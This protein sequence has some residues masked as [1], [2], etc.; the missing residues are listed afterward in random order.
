MTPFSGPH[1][2]I[3][4]SPVDEI[5]VETKPPFN[6]LYSVW[7]PSHF[8]TLLE[9]HF[10]EVAYRTFRLKSGLPVAIRMTPLHGGCCGIRAQVFAPRPFTGAERAY[11]S[12]RLRLAYGLDFPIKAFYE[13]V[14][15]D[16]ALVGGPIASLYGMR[17]SC[18][19]TL[20][21]IL[22]ISLVLQ[23]TTAKRSGQ[24]LAVLLET[25]GDSMLIDGQELY[26][27][28]DVNR[29]A[30]SSE[31]ELREGCRLG[32]R[33]RYLQAIAEG[34]ARGVV[35]EDRVRRLPEAEAKVEL[36]RL[37]GVGPYSAHVALSSALQNPNL[38]SLDVWNRKILSRFLFGHPDASAREVVEAAEARWNG[39][40]GLAALYIIEDLYRE[41]PASPLA[42]AGSAAGEERH[43]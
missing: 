2:I 42:E 37:K 9:R 8:P 11:L 6:F 27:F 10:G 29:L 43:R 21:E 32:Y 24:M 35:D 13:A 26:A 16:R 34:F 30:A 41:T 20:F 5:E 22:V 1:R 14:S 7:K 40:K 25:F 18:P 19:E 38:V 31:R 4:L 36:M 28:C 15:S 23:N 12:A 39:F 33:A 3:H 17:A